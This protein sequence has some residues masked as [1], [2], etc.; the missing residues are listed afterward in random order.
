MKAKEVRQRFLDFFES[1]QHKIIPSAP[2]VVKNDPTLMFI[3]AGMNQFKDIFL[4]HGQSD[5]NRVTDTQKCLR[6]SGKHNDLDEVGHDTYHHT[7]FEMLGNWSFGD[8]FKK[9]AIAW[10]WELLTEVYGLNPENLYV[11]VFEGDKADGTAFDQEAYDFW[12]AIIPDER[13]LNG[14]KKDNFWEMGESGPCG[15]CSEIHIDIRSKEEKA[16]IPGRDLINMDHPEVIEIWNLVFIE[17]NR[18]ANG[19]L[20]NL[21]EKHIDTG[22]G[23]ERLTM[24]V[25]GVRSNYDTDIFQPLIQKIAGETGF[26]YGKNK[27]KDI[28]MRVVADHIRALAFTIADGQLPSNVGAGYVI[29]RILRRAVRYAYSFLNKKEAFMYKILPILIQEMGDAFPELIKQEKLIT[30]VIQEE[31]NSFLNTLSTGIQRIEKIIEQLTLNQQ[32]SLSGKDAFELYDTFGF[33]FDLTELIVKENG[34]TVSKTEF[35]TFMKEQKERSRQASVSE[36]DDWVIVSDKNDGN[37]FVGYDS[38]SAKVNILK[39]RKI[40]TKNT[41]AY[42]LVFNQTP[43]YA[44]SGGQVGDTGFLQ[45]DAEKIN[46]YDTKK[47]NNLTVHFTKQ[48]PK[49]PENTFQAQ[50]I[51]GKRWKTANNHTAA[52]LMHHALRE[53]LGSH[54]EQKGSYV[55]ADYLRFDFA[56]F[57]KMTDEEIQKVEQHV[58]QAIWNN[59]PANIQNDIAIKEAEERGAIALFGEKYGDNVR[60]V[61]FADSVELCGG[62]HVEATGQ[63]GLFKILHESAIA[64][65]IRRIEAITG[66][67]AIAHYNTQSNELEQIKGILKGQKDLSKGVQN[68]QDENKK[69]QKQIDD[70]YQAKAS[71]I[72]G[73]LLAGAIEINGINIIT[74]TVDLDAN[75]IKNLVFALLRDTKK[76]LIALGGKNGNKVTLTIALTKDLIEEKGLDAGKIIRSVSKEIQGGGGGQAH[77]ATA[78][79]KNPDGLEKAYQL[80]KEQISN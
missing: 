64:A 50:V 31:E 6:V 60:V 67:K 1:K 8:Y 17:F 5:A 14:N 74:A 35:D 30:K 10:A 59:T 22:M 55:D 18:K 57:Q 24:A 39:Y 43:F 61:Q 66:E 69:L 76:T 73:N 4:G 78:G 75:N 15:P 20:E 36:T 49:N 13:I 19:Q 40:Q 21:P 72:K 2:M 80:I 65:G 54:V 26:V 79:G 33:P 63:I 48:L 27:K 77:F 32:K 7:M 42:Q 68:L 58:N 9:E 11:T 38:L 51:E 56:H 12:K 37:G 25:Q 52:H 71:S 62:T 53:V 28:A 16:K 41:T 29:R 45:N 46:I 3:N 23:F 44:E 70:L 47:E 34:L